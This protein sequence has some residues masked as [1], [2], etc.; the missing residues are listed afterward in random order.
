L[1]I[2]AAMIAAMPVS[3]AAQNADN[4]AAGYSYEIEEVIVTAQRREQYLQDTPV[5]VTVLSGEDLTSRMAGNLANVGDFVPNLDFSTATQSSRSSFVSAVFI[6]GVGQTD[7]IVTSDPAVGI[8][9]DGIYY[10]RTTGG[11]VDLL[12]IARVEVLRGPQ[13]T[14]FGKNTIGGA[15]NV[16]SEEPDEEFGG[17]AELTYGRFDLV[18][19]RGTVNVPLADNLFGRVAISTKNSNGYGK[20]LDFAT[21]EETAKLGKDDSIAGRAR[22]R[23]LPTDS[24]EANLAFDYTRV[25]EPQVPDDI[26]A[27]NPAAG[28][29]GLWNALVGFPSGQPYTPAYLTPDDYTSYATGPNISELDLWGA[30]LTLD[31]E[32]GPHHLKSITAYRDMESLFSNDGDG[33][34]TRN[35]GSDGVDLDQD[36]FS[37]ELQLF[38]KSFDD[39]LDWLAGLYYFEESALE[40]TSAYV[41]PGIFQALEALPVLI[42]PTGPLGPCPPP[43]VVA[44]LPTPG[45]LGCAGNPNNIPLDLD[46]HGTNDIEVTSYSAFGHANFALTDRWGVTAGLRYTHEEKTHDLEYMRLNSGFIIA[47]AGTRTKNSWDAWT[48]KAGLEFRPTDNLML[49]GSVSRGFRSG[50]FNGRPFFRESVLAY[51]PEYLWSYELGVKSDWFDRRLVANAS[52]FFNDYTDVQLTSNRATADGNVAIFTENGGEAEFKGFEIELQARPIERLDLIAGIGYVDAEFTKLNP[53]VTVTLDTVFPKAPKWDGNFSAQYTLPAGNIGTLS[54]RGDYAY[55]SRYYNDTANT[56]GLVQDAFGLVN[57]RIALE[58]SS[59][60]WELAVFG[61]NLTDEHYITG[62]VG[63]LAAIG[64][65]EVQYARPREWGVALT[66]RF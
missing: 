12:D 44:T 25:R 42:G 58:G 55:R 57:A 51:D 1:L 46:F 23:W 47:P 6:R 66:Y 22:L 16:V 20:Q 56:P 41:N 50:G 60:A 30:S 4:N 65:N 3:V 14:L 63:G 49:Y 21:G 29:M 43:P 36:Q 13:G 33:S 15:L 34:P 59:Q 18:K 35:L 64:F 9:V 7:F 11:V 48:P 27:I 19:F 24:M 28:L 17:V 62:G 2:T 10:G 39:R 37:Q 45:P 61:T 5:S 38:G 52:V 31:W 53:G 40:I 8:Y 32:L 54:L 26:Q